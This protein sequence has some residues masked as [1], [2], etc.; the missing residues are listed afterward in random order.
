MNEVA[1]MG[2]L[3]LCVS[4]LLGQPGQAGEEC[5]RPRLTKLKPRKGV[6]GDEITLNGSRFGAE[7]G[8]VTFAPDVN[9]DVVSWSDKSV[10][11]TVPEGVATGKVRVTNQCG[12]RSKGKKFIFKHEWLL[13]T[14]SGG[15][16]DDL[17][18][19]IATDADGNLLIAGD[20]SGVATF[21]ATIL[22][23]AGHEDLFVAKQS[24]SGTFQWAVRAGGTQADRATAIAVD[25]EGFI[26]VTG[27]FAGT[28]TFGD[29]TLSADYRADAFFAKL[30]PDGA[31]LWAV[32]GGG[33]G[34]DCGNAAAIDGDGDLL[35]AGVYER[36][37]MFGAET[38]P[39]AGP[40][41]LF[42]VK[43]SSSGSYVWA[44]GAGGAGDDRASSVAVDADGNALVAGTYQGA[45]TF[46]STEVT[47]TSE[48]EAFVAKLDSDGEFLWAASGRG[49]TRDSRWATA[50]ATDADGNGLLTGRFSGA[51]RF[52][53]TT[54]TPAGHFDLFVAKVS[55]DGDFLWATGAGGK[56]D[57]AGLSIAVGDEGEARITGFF[58]EKAKL[59]ATKLKSRGAQDVFV[60]AVSPEGY[61]SWAVRAGGPGIDEGRSIAIEADGSAILTGRFS[62]TATFGATSIDAVGAADVFVARAGLAP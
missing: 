55:P 52:G 53:Q 61:L 28:A 5:K 25:T 13:A 60:A 62:R 34:Y 10:V 24:P 23:S 50:I 12:K 56:R 4:L 38:L 42:V 7:A 11:V 19:A 39:A 27:C 17:S 57:D 30:S 37:A 3:V 47:T 22:G 59:G 9:A 49:S 31:F 48:R 36:D 44:V 41:D 15:T 58:S 43:L 32:R 40:Y 21:G 45:V 35:F 14:G 18:R 33:L 29:R 46:G 1:R 6:P 2:V 20:F 54:L 16:N 8:S 26:Y 51:A